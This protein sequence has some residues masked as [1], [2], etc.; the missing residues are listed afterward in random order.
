MLSDDDMVWLTRELGAT[1]ALL[2][3]QIAAAPLAIL[4]QDLQHYGRDQLA[5]A[6]GRVRME[7]T[8]Q[9]TPATFMH[10]LEQA[11]GRLPPAEAYALAMTSQDE[12]ATVVWTDEIAQAWGRCL[13]LLEE[14]DKFGARQAFT[15][16]Y[17]QITSQAR[18]EGRMPVVQVSWGADRELRAVAIEKAQRRG[19]LSTDMAQLPRAVLEE[20]ASTSD[21][22]HEALAML[23][24]PMQPKHLLPAPVSMAT[25]QAVE[26]QH[27]PSIEETQERLR[28]LAKELRDPNRMAQLSAHRAHLNQLNLRVRKAH[29]AAAAQKYLATQ[30]AAA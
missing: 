16:A 25:P 22:A 30:G 18:Y 9:L 15:E 26:H 28:Q 7:H 24:A 12:R 8:G 13:P 1:Y 20:L 17:A 27:K 29:V 3:K 23:P 6:M 11:Y 21:Q 5:M 14:G 19:L 10:Y 4:V 2:G